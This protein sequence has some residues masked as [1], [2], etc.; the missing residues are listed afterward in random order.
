VQSSIHTADYL[1]FLIGYDRFFFFR[2]LN[3]S[4][5]FLLSLA[6]NGSINV[7]EG[8]GKDFRY[9]QQKPGKPAASLGR[10]RGIPLCEGPA[11]TS[12][13][14]CVQVRPENFEDA[15]KFEGFLQTVIQSDFMHGR[16]SPRVVIITD[17]S[18]I[19][20]FAPTATYRISDSFLVGATYIA[21]AASRKAALATFRAHDM[22]QLRVTY[23][24]N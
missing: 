23:Q 7:S 20:A 1:R 8:D 6:F 15:N 5:S 2:P 18:G 21:I 24:L 12:N 9:P 14:L 11:A 22:V 17:V 4:N 10:I 19:F 13:P 16:L 3:P